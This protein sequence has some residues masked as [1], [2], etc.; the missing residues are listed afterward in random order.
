M[1]WLVGVDVGGTF[2][3]F[4][5]SRLE[6]GAT[7]IFKR[8]STPH[9]PGEAIVRGLQEMAAALDVDPAAIA[10]LCHGTTV[11][12]NALIQ[13]RGGTVALVTTEGFRDLL[14]IGR[15]TRPHMYSLQVDHP[16]P[17]V[18]RRRRFE[19]RERLGPGGEVLTALDEAGLAEVADAV[20]A[21]GAQSCA[22][23]CLFS[24]VDPAHERR[25]A[26]A[27]KRRQPDLALSLS[28][29]VRP[30]FREYERFS[31]TVLNAYLQPVIAGYLAYLEAETV[32][33]APDAAIRIYQSSG[34]LMSVET[35]RAY[36]IRTALSGPA[37]GAVGAVHTARG[38]NRPNVITLDMG[39]T[40]AD[41]ALI[42]EYDAGIGLNREVA[43]YPVRQPTVDIHTVGAGGGSIAWF[44]RDGLLKVGPR[45]AGAE[46]GPACYGRGG[47]EPT[48]TDANLVLGRLS[49][50]GLAGGDLALDEGGGAARHR[51]D[52]G[53]S[54]LPGRENRAR[55]SRDRRR[56]LWCAPCGPSRSSAASTR[57]ATRLM[58]FGGAGPLHAVAVARILGIGEIV[59]PGAPGILCAQ[60]L[61][62]SDLKEEFVRS[63]RFPLTA[64]GLS[65]I[66]ALLDRLEDE[67][68]AWFEA[69]GVAPEA[70]GLA[71]GFD[72][73]YVGQNFELPVAFAA[74]AP[75]ALA[76]PAAPD[77]VAEAFHAE[78]ERHY[79]FHSAGE[80]IEIVNI[81][82][83]A[84][85]RIAAAA[86]APASD[87]RADRA[88]EPAGYRP[89]WFD[90]DSAVE[91]PVY[92]RESLA[93]GMAFAG[94]AIVEQLDSTT[95][96][97]PGDRA[98]VD[99]AGNL[100]IAVGSPDAAAAGVAT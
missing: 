43:G 27:L 13:R 83:A 54:R 53:P 62:V 89:V 90:G 88:P 49:P 64:D 70:R 98:A 58:P 29:S 39:G 78:H 56:Q 37:A 14:E 36:P 8:P 95:V 92:R 28:S 5:A 25:I 21:S 63:G 40:S 35:A 67:A 96:A 23:C 41:V 59:V 48:V 72:A 82:I 75:G 45:S 30:E 85:G 4:F 91:T 1:G 68:R 73:R 15:Q 20:A 22:V 50:A 76:R 19:V 17:L 18:P 44:E 65:Q 16:A 94:P 6:D 77:T 33:L 57:A 2:T 34:G 71:L 7:R 87:R 47:T 99:A 61:I 100:V 51:T 26:D 80:P 84:T 69:E 42:R 66:G 24:F 11:A 38:A 52:R 81:R 74:E 60:G 93:A 3:D 97:F 55:H 79:G 12:T 10:R 32:A 9:N 46:P 86:D 31:T